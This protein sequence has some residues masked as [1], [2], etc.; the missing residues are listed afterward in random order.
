MRKIRRSQLL[1]DGLVF[2][3]KLWLDSLKDFTL[4]F[5]ALGAAVVDYARAGKDEPQLFQRVMLYGQRFDHWLDL[6]GP[7]D[8]DKLLPKRKQKVP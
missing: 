1:R 8:P 6:Y 7:F 3:A 4:S 5:L 2:M